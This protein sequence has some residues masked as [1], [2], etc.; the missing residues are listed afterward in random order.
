MDIPSHDGQSSTRGADAGGSEP[1]SLP[2]RRTLLMRSRRWMQ[3]AL[4][5]LVG[6]L[7]LELDPAAGGLEGL[8]SRQSYHVTLGMRGGLPALVAP[9]APAA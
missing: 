3:V 8:H 4:A 1:C 5:L 9:R 6:R 2:S 7:R